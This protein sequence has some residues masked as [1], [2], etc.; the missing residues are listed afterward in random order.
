MDPEVVINCKR[1]DKK[2]SCID[3]V[4]T[5]LVVL[6]AFVLGIVLGAATG[7]VET[8]GL[9][10]FLAILTVFAVLAILTLIYRLCMCKNKKY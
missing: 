8:I 2:C 4:I 3:L 1:K 9:V 6:F 5:I 10:Y 7:I